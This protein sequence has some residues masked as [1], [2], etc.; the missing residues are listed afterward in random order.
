[1]A[2]IYTQKGDDGFT[3]LCEVKRISKSSPI[4]EAIGMVDEVNSLLGL[5]RAVS[6]NK[7]IERILAK[8][9]HDLCTLSADLS[10]VDT[11]K[12]DIPRICER[13]IEML[14]KYIDEIESKLPPLNKFVIPAGSRTT[15]ML[16]TG[17]SICR[18]AERAIVNAMDKHKINPHVLIYLNRLSDLL[19]VLA[20]KAN[21]D[22]KIKEEIWKP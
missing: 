22:A 11:K 5:C 8:I 12:S 7:Q 20:R 13:H 1:M 10:S 6:K 14:E 19:F 9:Q 21:I 15:A 17:R 2:K 3:S 4:I 18:R 16:H